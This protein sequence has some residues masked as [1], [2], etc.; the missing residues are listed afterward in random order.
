M[1]TG[2]YINERIAARGAI[3]AAD[4]QALNEIVEAQKM[5]H[6]HAAAKGSQ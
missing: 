3:S 5:G 4:F 2:T 6:R 1:L